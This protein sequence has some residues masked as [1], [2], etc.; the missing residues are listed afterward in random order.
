MPLAASVE[1][2]FEPESSLARY[3]RPQLPGAAEESKRPEPQARPG[4]ACG[5]AGAAVEIVA[6]LNVLPSFCGSPE[7][8]AG[9]GRCNGSVFYIERPSLQRSRLRK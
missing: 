6:S 1:Y 5:W 7:A 9:D 4:P 8:E 2:N 3:L